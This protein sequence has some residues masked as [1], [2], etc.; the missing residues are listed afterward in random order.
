MSNDPNRDVAADSAA[1]GER[2]TEPRAD[3]PATDDETAAADRG[4]D[5]VDLG[6]TAEHFEEM[7]ERERIDDGRDLLNP[8]P[9]G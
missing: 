3:R 5:S 9:R 8:T 2:F 7:V 1:Q 4:A 6:R